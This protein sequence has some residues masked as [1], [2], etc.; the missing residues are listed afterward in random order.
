MDFKYFFDLLA[1]MMTITRICTLLFY[2]LSSRHYVIESY[3]NIYSY[4]V[5]GKV[6]DYI[7]AKEVKTEIKRDS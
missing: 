5:S 1:S 6:K 7:F 3:T 2:I 4:I